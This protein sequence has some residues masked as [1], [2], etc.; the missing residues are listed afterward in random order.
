MLES[1]HGA[2]VHNAPVGAQGT[3]LVV[4]F[5][6]GPSDLLDRQV[7]LDL[8][9]LTRRLAR[10]SRTRAVVIW[11]PGRCLPAPHHDLSEIAD[12]AEELGLTTPTRVPGWESL[13]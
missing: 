11:D 10:D 4:C 6:N 2:D 5:D 8:D 7:F 12:G 9:N 13:R 3:T 1:G